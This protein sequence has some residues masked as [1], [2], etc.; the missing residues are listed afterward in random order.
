MTTIAWDGKTLAADS[1]ATTSS[2][3][4][5][6]TAKIVRSSKGFVAAGAGS[7]NAV[8][9]WL[10]WVLAGM[11]PEKQPDTLADS[12]TILIVDPRGRA[13]TFEGSPVR[14][15][16]RDKI[17]ALGSGAD[18]A[19]GAMAMGADARTAVKVAC[20]FDVYSGG[21]IIALAPGT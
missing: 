8:T 4:R 3:T 19:L 10:R 6:R 2:G 1:Q 14:L 17:W 15:P 11:P 18:F 12:S 21:R 9:P 20:R 7:L 13:F 5:C 16:L